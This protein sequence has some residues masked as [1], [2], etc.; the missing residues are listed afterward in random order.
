MVLR[1]VSFTTH[2]SLAHPL[3]TRVYSRAGSVSTGA[4]VVLGAHLVPLGNIGLVS[5]LVPLPPTPSSTF[6]SSAP[7]CSSGGVGVGGSLST[8]ESLPQLG[9]LKPGLDQ[10]GCQLGDFFILG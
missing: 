3:A 8:F 6:P 7:H 2:L 1:G 10:L 4:Q 5:L 9:I